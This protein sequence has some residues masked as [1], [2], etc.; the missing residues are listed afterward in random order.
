M[1]KDLRQLKDQTPT[2]LLLKLVHN[3]QSYL[4]W[5]ELIAFYKTYSD[6]SM[7]RAG[8]LSEDKKTDALRRLLLLCC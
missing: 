4:E 1:R 6:V 2:L 7:K 5:V 8:E 3:G